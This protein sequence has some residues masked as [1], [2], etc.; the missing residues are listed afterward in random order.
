MAKKTPS[1]AQDKLDAI[2]TEAIASRIADGETY[3]EIAGSV[4]VGLGRLA[5]WIDSD[6]ERSQACARARE[7]SAQSFE[8][9]AQEEIEDAKDPFELA[10]ARELAVHWRWRAKAVN[11]RRYGDKVAVGGAEDL[12]AM[13]TDATVTLTAEEAYKRM[14]AGG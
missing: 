10:K 2:G 7:T 5:M 13:K 14:L 9:R 3:R 8:E 4:G 12:P 1:P 11:P 6:P